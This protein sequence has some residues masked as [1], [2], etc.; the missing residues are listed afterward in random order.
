MKIRNDIRMVRQARRLV[1]KEVNHKFFVGRTK[2]KTR[3]KIYGIV[4]HD[5]ENVLDTKLTQET[6][7]Y[8]LRERRQRDKEMK[9][10]IRT[11]TPKK[12]IDNIFI[13]KVTYGSTTK[14][15]T[16]KKCIKP[17]NVEKTSFSLVVS[18]VGSLTPLIQ[19]A[20][21][22][23]WAKYKL[24]FLPH[25]RLHQHLFL[26]PQTTP[27]S[28]PPSP[29][30]FPQSP[31]AASSPSPSTPNTIP[32]LNCFTGFLMMRFLIGW[33]R[34]EGRY[35][36]TLNWVRENLRHVGEE[37]D[38]LG[39]G[40]KYPVAVTG[41]VGFIGSGQPSFVAIR[42]DMDALPMQGFDFLCYGLEVI[43]DNGADM[44]ALPMQIRMLRQLGYC[45]KGLGLLLGCGIISNPLSSPAKSYFKCCSTTGATVTIFSIQQN[46][47]IWVEVELETI[48]RIGKGSRKFHCNSDLAL[49]K[50]GQFGFKLNWK[51]FQGLKGRQKA[52]ENSI[53]TQEAVL[54]MK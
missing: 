43:S 29:L 27:A 18:P 2:P 46:G 37:L 54:E 4:A 40:Y 32:P 49:N 16:P 30:S 5:K 23:S 48:S 51:P 53:A 10:N 8:R 19:L 6:L 12:G 36:R 52:Q 7:D 21:R 35:M 45:Y 17:Y 13:Y 15:K 33:W 11:S 47:S 31:S 41:V 38:K 44:D 42:A 34:S 14:F 22:L 3:W 9:N 50:M 1:S 25:Y 28:P 24:F 20:L 26:Q 39:I